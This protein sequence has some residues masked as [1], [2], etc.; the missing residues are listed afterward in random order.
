MAWNKTGAA[1]ETRRVV[2]FSDCTRILVVLSC[3]VYTCTDCRNSSLLYKQVAHFLGE[4][5][6]VGTLNKINEEKEVQTFSE[7]VSC[8]CLIK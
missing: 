1:L 3:E 4:N 6:Q 8:R 7:C 2:L 5:P